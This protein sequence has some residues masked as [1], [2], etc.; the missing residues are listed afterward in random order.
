MN[1]ADILQNSNQFQLPTGIGNNMQKPFA[2][3]ESGSEST[4]SFSDTLDNYIQDVNQMQ[5]HSASLSEKFIKGEAV[6][7]HDVMI[8][9]EK[10]KTSFQLL[11]E[12]RNKGL[13]LYKEAIRIQV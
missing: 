9:A 4:V 13:D 7:M 5:K 12:L 2:Q 8:S 1:I 3:Q 11:M 10:A 6:D